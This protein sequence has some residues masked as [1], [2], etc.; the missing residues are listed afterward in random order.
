MPFDPSDS[1]CEV[2]AHLLK[3]CSEEV[4]FHWE[5]IVLCCWALLTVGA[6]LVSTAGGHLYRPLALAC[7]VSS[8]SAP[9]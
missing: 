9:G 4:E 5:R 7:R 1:S 6:V 2:G 3:I 8:A